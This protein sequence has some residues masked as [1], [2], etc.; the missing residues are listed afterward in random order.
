MKL[1][2]YIIFFVSLTGIALL[3]NCHF[4]SGGGQQDPDPIDFDNEDCKEILIDEL[5]Y[6]AAQTDEY[7]MDYA[8]IKGDTLNVIVKYGGGCGL[9]N[10]R[11]ITNGLFMESHPVQLDVILS[12]NDE[13]P[14]EALITKQICFNILQLATLYNDSYQTG[15]GTIILRLKDY[16]DRLVYDF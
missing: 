2:V 16:D 13:D 15:H 9:A 4:N 11:L 7:E 10:F 5:K 12:F 3:F 1:S 14:C 8:Y 6:D